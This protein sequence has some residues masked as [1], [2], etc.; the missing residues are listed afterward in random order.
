MSDDIYNVDCL[1]VGAGVV[2]LAAAI[3]LAKAGREVLV[4]ET[5]TQLGSITSAR[6]SGVIH[7]GLYYPTDSYK[8]RFCVSGRRRLYP[9]LEKHDVLHKKCGKLIVAV[10]E[11]DEAKLHALHAQAEANQVEGVRLLSGAEAQALE[12]SIT[13]RAA[14]IS[15]ESG[16]LDQHGYIQALAHQ[17]EAHDGIIVRASPFLGAAPM[18]D[19]RIEA[20]IGGASSSRVRCNFLLNA[21]GLY[22]QR[23][24][25]A[26]E[27]LNAEHIPTLHLAK[28]SYFNLPG[29][30]PFQRLIY[31]LPSE[32]GLGVHATLDLG[33][34]VRFGP[35]VEFLQTDDPDQINYNVDPA[36]AA[37]YET[38]V[39][40]YWPAMPQDALQPG[41]TGVRPKLGHA[42]HDFRIDG[43]EVHGIRGLVNL[44]GIESPGLTSSLA[45][46]EEAAAHAQTNWAKAT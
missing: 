37:S 13:C 32:S 38:I 39:R 19:G 23:V 45:L 41:Y 36:R 17:I 44:F 43:E 46:G 30:A 5:Q 22:A 18:P 42:F 27:G 21:A 16:I 7:A 11:A 26:I 10:T 29:K 12:P 31:P 15:P 4:V 8:H 9:F 20:R 3:S 33:G 2:G 40:S 1:V 25:T 14:L 34:Q 35:D 28:G 24:A 6:N